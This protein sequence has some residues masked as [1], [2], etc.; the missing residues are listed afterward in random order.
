MGLSEISSQW[1]ISEILSSEG[2][3]K[4]TLPDAQLPQMPSFSEEKQLYSSSS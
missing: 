2:V 4:A 3:H 1:N